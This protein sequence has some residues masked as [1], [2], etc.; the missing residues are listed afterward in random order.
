MND[1]RIH[2]LAMLP[3]LYEQ[4]LFAHAVATVIVLLMVTAK[5]LF[6]QT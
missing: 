4:T 5:F 3:D 6:E 1:Y 2:V